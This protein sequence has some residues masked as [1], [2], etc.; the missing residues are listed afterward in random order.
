MAP[1]PAA[2]PE[3]WCWTRAICLRIL[4]CVDAVA[5]LRALALL[6]RGFYETFRKHERRL[7]G[8]LSG[9]GGEVEAEAEG[10]GGGGEPVLDGGRNADGKS[11]EEDGDEVVMA[12]ATMAMSAA[13]ARRRGLRS[14]PWSTRRRQVLPRP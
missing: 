7:V 11:R 8:A 1:A 10:E 13:K 14:S 3:G 5:D 4:Q 9:S 6:N 12:V 2:R